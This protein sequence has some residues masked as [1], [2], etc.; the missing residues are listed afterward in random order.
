MAK[1]SAEDKA[2]CSI[3]TPKGRVSHPHLFTATKMKDV[4]TGKES[5]DARYSIGMLFDKT[6]VSYKEL[7]RPVVNAMVLKFGRDQSTWPE[8]WS[9]PVRDGDKVPKKKKEIKPEHA[10]MWVVKASSKEEFGRPHVLGANKRPLE[11]EADLYPGCYAY[12]SLFATYF[13]FADKEGITFIL[14]GV[15]KAYAMGDK[16]DGES[17][18]GKKSVDEMFGAVEGNDFEDEEI[19]DEELEDLA[20]DA[21]ADF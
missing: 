18:G 3:L 7:M 12:V 5:G 2:K 1:I 9:R 17:L 15:M 19:S 4:K 11:R 13:E 21:E 14:D 6:E 16:K 10:G 20:D 8:G